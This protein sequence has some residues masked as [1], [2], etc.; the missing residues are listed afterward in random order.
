MSK[1]LALAIDPEEITTPDRGSD[2]R[3]IA[4][5]LNRAVEDARSADAYAAMPDRRKKLSHMLTPK[6]RD[7][8]RRGFWNDDCVLA[9]D[10]IHFLMTSRCHKYLRLLDIDPEL[11]QEQLIQT[12]HKECTT[13]IEDY[14]SEGDIRSEGNK[15]ASSYRAARV[16]A[17]NKKRR[18]FRNNYRF[19]QERLRAVGGGSN[20]S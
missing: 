14:T 11:F 6:E 15:K 10:A 17:E 13:P 16:A 5:I 2:R 4:E 8:Q 19:Y 7:R 3:L 1:T 9:V 18:I 12:Q 20:A